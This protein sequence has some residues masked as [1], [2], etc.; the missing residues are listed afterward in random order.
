ML[1]LKY[2]PKT[3][4]DLDNS[5]ARTALTSL[6]K[7]KILPHALLFT[8]QKGT[9]K[10]SSARIFAK[11]VNCLDNIFNGRGDSY[12]PCNVCVSCSAVERGSSPDV[13]EMDAA[14][15]RGIEEVKGIIREASFAPMTSK[16]RVFIIDEAHMITNEGFNALLKTLEEPP[17]SVI[18]I[19]ATTH[20]EKLPPTI[21]S[22]CYTVHFGTAEKKDIIEKLQKIAESENILVDLTVLD[23]IS[24]RGDSS[25]RDSIKLFEELILQNKLD[26]ESAEA[27]LG[28]R[29][30]EGL[31]DTIAHKTVTDALEW[32]DQY[33]KHGGSIKHLI[34]DLLENLRLQLLKSKGISDEAEVL[35]KTQEIMFL[36]KYLQEAYTHLRTSPIQSLPLEIAIVEFY[37][38]RN[39]SQT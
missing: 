16:Y 12:E 22:R 30:K 23:L 18:F 13:L 3:I 24:T 1:Y 26:L 4:K 6:L 5:A 38:Y 7:S 25:F 31:F 10:T 37:N 20:E 11:A 29:S 32:I 8:G 2:R 34:E 27:Y 33:S 21:V 19:L 35:F 28:A 39:K 14:S 36:M 17:E 15:N 9:G